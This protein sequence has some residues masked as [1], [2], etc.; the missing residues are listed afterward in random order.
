VL[1]RDQ[2]ASFPIVGADK[3][4]VRSLDDWLAHAGPKS[5]KQWKEGRSAK[6]LAK[7]WLGPVVPDDLAD[8]L[9]SHTATKGFRID[10]ARAEHVTRLDN[11]RGEQRNHDLVLFGATTG[12]KTVVGIEAKADES[13]GDSLTDYLRKAKARKTKTPT[14]S[15]ERLKRL[16]TQLFGRT[17]KD[18]PKL[19]ELRFQLLS[20]AAG[21]LI[22]AKNS[23]SAQAVL[24]VH[25][26]HSDGVRK[27]K[28][29]ANRA[30]VKAFVRAFGQV[31]V[32]RGATGWLAGPIAVP[33]AQRPGDR[34][35]GDVPLHIGLLS[36]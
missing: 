24:I 15:P 5:K 23:G 30:A 31:R 34:V 17:L 11:F 7:A 35:P 36:S 22:E 16:T 6:E 13:L 25:E 28:V 21:T 3:H 20:A 19:G 8:F 1:T 12:K 32:P 2:R 29:D 27:P 14:K 9:A 33:G 18:D 10:N 26:F 4:A